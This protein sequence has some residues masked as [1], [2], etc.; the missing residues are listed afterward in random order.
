MA[1]GSSSGF[2]GQLIHLGAVR[3]RVIGSGNL[4]TDT[5]SLNDLSNSSVL[6]DY[7]MLS[8][9]NRE[10]TVLANFIDQRIQLEIRTEEID[11]WYD[12][13]KIVMYARQVAT[14]YPQ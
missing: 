14:G 8:A 1:K 11:E 10:L 2:N 13:S 12:I 3:Y 5:H 6:P 4:L 9:T 7:A